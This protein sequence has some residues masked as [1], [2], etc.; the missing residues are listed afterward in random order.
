VVRSLVLRLGISDPDFFQ[1]PRPSPEEIRAWL[2]WA[3]AKLLAM[4]ISSPKPKGPHTAWPEFAQDS[5]QAYGYTNERLRAAIPRSHEIELMDEIQTLP[6]LID[7][8]TVRRIV[9]ARSLVTPVANRYVYS[10]TKIAYMIH[11]DRRK[12]VRLHFSGLNEIAKKIPPEQTYAIKTSLSIF[13][14]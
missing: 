7:D 12:V 14:A 8:I 4:H 3:G 9:N 5:R 2:E 1:E 10:W 6:A 11:S 13:T